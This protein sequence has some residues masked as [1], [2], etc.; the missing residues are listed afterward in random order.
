[1][2]G[3]SPPQRIYLLQTVRIMNDACRTS[4]SV[5][6]MPW[7]MYVCIC[8]HHAHMY[9]VC[10][11]PRVFCWAQQ[12]PTNQ[13]SY[14]ISSQPFSMSV[15]EIR[16]CSLHVW[17]LT[18]LWT[19]FVSIFTSHWPW[20]RAGS[21]LDSLHPPRLRLG[22]VKKES[23]LW[24]LSPWITPQYGIT[25]QWMSEDTIALNYTTEI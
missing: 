1:M 9:P 24:L 14:S 7:N 19:S 2:W 20:D 18:S 10:P 23:S 22:W 3:I 25:L 11:P 17:I 8:M 5:Y 12:M 13:N 4:Q 6:H 15:P 21:M 16:H